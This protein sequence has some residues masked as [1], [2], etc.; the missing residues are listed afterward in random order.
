MAR[1]FHL[2]S[3][4][5]AALLTA[6]AAYTPASAQSQP[7]QKIDVSKLGPQ[8]GYRV[9]DFDLKEQ[10]GKNF[11]LKSIIG[12]KGA[13]LSQQK[14]NN[15]LVQSVSSVVSKPSPLSHQFFSSPPHASDPHKLSGRPAVPLLIE[16]DQLGAEHFCA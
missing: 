4:S 13:Q 2:I 7:H 8:V 1:Q 6:V 3:V 12:P 14:I 16:F 5:A 9:P 11:N 10:N 15:P